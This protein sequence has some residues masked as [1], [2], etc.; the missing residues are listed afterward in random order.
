MMFVVIMRIRLLS[1]M[2]SADLFDLLMPSIASSACSPVNPADSHME[3][4]ILIN[5]LSFK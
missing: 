2:L 4:S 3:V 5:G 1:H